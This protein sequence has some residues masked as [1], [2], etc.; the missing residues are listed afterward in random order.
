MSREREEVQKES[1]RRL[2]TWRRAVLEPEPWSTSPEIL[3]PE[4]YGNSDAIEVVD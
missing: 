4:M 1:R 3:L 2:L